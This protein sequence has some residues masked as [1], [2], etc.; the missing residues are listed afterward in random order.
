MFQKDRKLILIQFH[1]TTVGLDN[2][3]AWLSAKRFLLTAKRIKKKKLKI[4][5]S[6]FKIVVRY[7]DTEL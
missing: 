3:S 4:E 5:V 6:C 7:G 2:F 1:D